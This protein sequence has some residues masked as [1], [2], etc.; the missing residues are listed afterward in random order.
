MS[1][2]DEAMGSLATGDVLAD[3]VLRSVNQPEYSEKEKSLALAR[4]VSWISTR[5]LDRETV[6][7]KSARELMCGGALMFEYAAMAE[8][9]EIGE[10]E[11]EL[12][13]QTMARMRRFQQAWGMSV[14]QHG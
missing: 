1:T 10:I 8:A 14:N 11:A 3:D 2:N 5:D 4:V 13:T 9:G 12:V 6:K 7:M